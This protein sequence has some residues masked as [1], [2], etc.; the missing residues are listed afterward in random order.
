ME[1]M[2]T[3]FVIDDEESVR[4]IVERYLEREGFDVYSFADG[5]TALAR[6]QNAMPDMVILD[7]MLPGVSGYDVCKWIRGQSDIPIIM[8][9]AR[10]EEVDRILGLELGS[11]D[12]LS[13]PFSPRELVAR[14]RTV[15]RR[16]RPSV[17]TVSLPVT[18]PVCADLI[19]HDDERRI[20]CREEDLVL[21]AK[22]FEL[23]AYFI[24]HKGRAFTREQLLTQVWGY[25][26]IGDERAIDDLVK[27][28]RK[29][30]GIKA[31]HAE[32][33]TVWG[34]GYKLEQG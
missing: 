21:T 29:K 6:M 2:R 28:L 12:Y 3:I 15:F 1:S 9:S 7:I 25:D 20:L 8:V 16:L 26:F 10:D 32:I 13:K 17:P 22:E 18:Y 14:V 27:R 5:E 34:Y 4:T 33:V 11:D 19:L 24:C 23:L 31:S 30:L